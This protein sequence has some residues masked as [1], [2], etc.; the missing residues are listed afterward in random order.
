VRRL[1]LQPGE[2]KR[3][4]LPLRAE[5]LAAYDDEGRP[6][7]EPGEF[8]ISIG[9]GQPGDPRSVVLMTTLIVG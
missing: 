6:F 1:H 8:Q 9:G 4:E 3:I 2:E 7:V 5:Q